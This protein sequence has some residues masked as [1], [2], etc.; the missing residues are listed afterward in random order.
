MG[1]GKIDFP[2]VMRAIAEIGFEGFA[3]LETSS[4]AHSIEADMNRNLSYIKKV[5]GA[6]G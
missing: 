4:P 5:M 3:N 6:N 1:E 2:A